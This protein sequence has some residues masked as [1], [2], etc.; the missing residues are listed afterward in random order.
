MK[1]N[2]YYILFIIA[3]TTNLNAFDGLTS[4]P[5]SHIDITKHALT[6]VFDAEFYILSSE[7]KDDVDISNFPVYNY[8]I[9]KSK[10][11]T[12]ADILAIATRLPDF[13]YFKYPYA[14]AQTANL[15]T[16]KS[17]TDTE[18]FDMELQALTD[19]FFY[20]TDNLNKTEQH[21]NSGNLT[22][23][24]YFYGLYL[25]SFQDIFSHQGITNHIHRYYDKYSVSPDINQKLI[26]LANEYT[27][28]LFNNLNNI[29]SSENY[30]IMKEAFLKK[31][32]NKE[33]TMKEISK[34]FDK[35][36]D[37]YIEGIFYVLSS[38]PPK[39]KTLKYIDKITWD[40]PVVADIIINNKISEIKSSD[41]KKKV[42]EILKNENY[43]F[44][45]SFFP[46]P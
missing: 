37:L 34:L 8:E 17:Y 30:K 10:H 44:T 45:R 15:D 31:D 40:F 32:N 33:L 27:V 6:D 26:T 23:A 9:Y 3:L 13:F 41:D 1:N 18:L 42:L 11:I 22:E 29:L 21:I 14:H 4:K 7:Q 43:D 39:E 25:H 12:A 16:D 2:F 19:F 20:M 28:K 46:T 38:I 35:K 36:N 5:G 24:L